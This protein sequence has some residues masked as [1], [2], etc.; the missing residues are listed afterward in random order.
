MAFSDDIVLG[1]KTY[2][3]TIQRPTNSVRS[4]S[5]LAVDTPHLVTLSHETAKN[6]KVSSVAIVDFTAATTCTDTCGSAYDD[7]RAMFK[8]Q[9][10]PTIGVVNL[11]TVIDNSIADLIAFLSDSANLAKLKN[12]EI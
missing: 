5:T 6:G 12:K 9:Y 2:S 4:D 10:N 1:T 3:L 11:D 8:L 7:V